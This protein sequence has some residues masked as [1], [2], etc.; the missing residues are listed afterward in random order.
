MRQILLDTETTGLSPQKG[1]RIVELGCVEMIDGLLTGNVFHAYL[2]PQGRKS[3]PRAYLVH[4]LTDDFLATRQC[5]S[6]GVP[7]FLHFI[8]GAEVIIHNAPF[9]MKFV[10]SELELANDGITDLADFCTIHDTLAQARALYPGARHSLDALCDRFN[11]VTMSRVVHGALIDCYSLAKVYHK[12]QEA[13][14]LQ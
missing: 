9:V 2:N 7:A 12:L 8:Q 1:D 3:H 13:E 11:I 14:K 5:F 4:K 6:T 10:N